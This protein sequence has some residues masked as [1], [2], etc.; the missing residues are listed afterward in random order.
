MLTW[1]QQPNLIL[2]LIVQ[3]FHFFQYNLTLLLNYKKPNRTGGL[4]PNPFYSNNYSSGK[5]PIENKL[6]REALQKL[7]GDWISLLSIT[8]KADQSYFIMLFHTV[9]KSL[10]CLIQLRGQHYT[11]INTLGL[12]AMPKQVRS[13]E[14]TFPQ[15]YTQRAAAHTGSTHKVN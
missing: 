3:F 12:A 6:K 8:L 15:T 4:F 13:K 14:K 7:E 2:N 10:R 1:L 9:S 11:C 5:K